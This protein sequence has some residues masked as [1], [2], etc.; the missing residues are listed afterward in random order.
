MRSGSFAAGF[1]TLVSFIVVVIL[2]FPA[3][4]IAKLRGYGFNFLY[5][6]IMAI[7]K[8]SSYELNFFNGKIF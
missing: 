8:M 5:G 6:Q 1:Y 4:K 3:L 7:Q 2:F